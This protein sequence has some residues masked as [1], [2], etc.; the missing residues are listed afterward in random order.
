LQT[1]EKLHCPLG[2]YQDNEM[3]GACKI[4]DYD[5]YCPDVG[6]KTPVAC[7]I[8]WLC[9][10]EGLYTH[11]DG[12]KECPEG[13]YCPAGTLTYDSTQSVLPAEDLHTNMI[14]CP[15]GYYCPKG[16]ADVFSKYGNFST[17]QPCKDGYICGQTEFYNQTNYTI[18][19]T[20]LT[21]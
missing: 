10:A 17:P 14:R 6:L 11:V 5:S 18:G 16:T 4:C 7:P 9:Q 20:D 8:G 21:L 12:M 2:S 13:Y 15:D 3:Q 1:F 19:S